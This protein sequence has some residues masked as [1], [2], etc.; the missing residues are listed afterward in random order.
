MMLQIFM[1]LQS[2]EEFRMADMI[3]DAICKVGGITYFDFILAPKSTTLN[4]LRG[5]CCLL[6]WD[7]G[8]HA[9]RMAKLMKRT[10][11]NVLNQQRMYRNLLQAKDKITVDIYNKVRDELKLQIHGEV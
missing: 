6:A 3:I 11:G 9:R 1:A 2:C 4:T 7:Y 10:R 5:V 8:V